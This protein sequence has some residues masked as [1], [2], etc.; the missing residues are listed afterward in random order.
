MTAVHRRPHAPVDLYYMQRMCSDPTP[1]TLDEVGVMLGLKS[2]TKRAEMWNNTLNYLN[3]AVSVWPPS[4][5]EM[6]KRLAAQGPGIE[7]WPPHPSVLPVPDLPWTDARP[8][9]TRGAVRKWALEVGRMAWSLDLSPRLPVGG[10]SKPRPTV[11]PVEPA[12]LETARRMVEFDEL[13]DLLQIASFFEVTEV[14]A[15]NWAQ[16][17]LNRW[18]NGVN[19]WPPSISEARRVDRSRKMG[20][21]TWWP[22]H[23]RV[24][25]A[26]AAVWRGRKMLPATNFRRDEGRKRDLNTWQWNAADVV[27]WGLHTGRIQPDGTV[28]LLHTA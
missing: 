2:R 23:Q 18:Q 6:G 26:P 15:R 4:G 17:S 22:D 12:D 1:V 28:V 16:A 21:L 5:P 13:W 7:W 14:T 9:W 20:R 25:P 10:G 8:R 19:T 27:W 24:L 3:G 11:E